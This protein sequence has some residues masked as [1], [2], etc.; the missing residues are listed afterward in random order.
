MLAELAPG[1]DFGEVHGGR[2]HAL[3]LFGGADRAND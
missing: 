3:G 1:G 2:G